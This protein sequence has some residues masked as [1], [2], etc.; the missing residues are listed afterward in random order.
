MEDWSVVGWVQSNLCLCLLNLYLTLG[1]LQLGWDEELGPG[2]FDKSKIILEFIF[3]N[4]DS[5]L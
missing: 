5:F 3:Y 4:I 1:H 2:L